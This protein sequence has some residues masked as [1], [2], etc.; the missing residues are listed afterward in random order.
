M[1]LAY[2]LKVYRRKRL[3]QMKMD[4]SRDRVSQSL[5][6]DESLFFNITVGLSKNVKL[7]SV[8]NKIKAA[9]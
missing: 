5:M 1:L 6:L 7:S 8:I 4:R 9:C 3:G 2:K